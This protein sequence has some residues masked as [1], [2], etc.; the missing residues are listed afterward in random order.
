MV[1]S[2]EGYEVREYQA[3]KWAST[4]VSEMNLQEAERTG[5][6]VRL[7]SQTILPGCFSVDKL[8]LAPI[9]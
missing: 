9:F 8:S 6:M 2:H 4:V 1:G 5:F 3:T 7:D